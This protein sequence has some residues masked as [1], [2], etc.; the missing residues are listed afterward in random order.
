MYQNTGLT[1]KI[2]AK[3][4]FLP[5]D[6]SEKVFFTR[7]KILVVNN[8]YLLCLFAIINHAYET[9]LVFDL[10]NYIVLALIF[11][12]CLACVLFY[13]NPKEIV[14]FI[15]VGL[16][17]VNLIT[18][19]IALNIDRSRSFYVLSWVDKN[20][21]N[22]REGSLDLKLV[23]SPEKSNLPAIE[24]RIIE[25]QKRGLLEITGTTVILTSRGEILIK[26]SNITADVLGLR[27]WKMN[28]F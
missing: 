2:L 11:L 16:V 25:Q 6:T 28:N 22:Y 3:I 4:F 15:V 14:A 5:K 13:K 27:N 18:Q 8:I 17:S 19:A 26:F 20:L 24:Q 21:I 9:S 1:S 10:I 12:N 7:I 23:K